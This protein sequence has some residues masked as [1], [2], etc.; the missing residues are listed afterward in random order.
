M[1]EWIIQGIK[2]ENDF[3]Y[4][5]YKTMKKSIEEAKKSNV[6]DFFMKEIT[7]VYQITKGL[8][9]N[10]MPLR[11]KTFNRHLPIYSYMIFVL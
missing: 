5:I 6:K 9:F 3:V 2:S 4:E 7:D 10:P 8:T 1:D 11:T